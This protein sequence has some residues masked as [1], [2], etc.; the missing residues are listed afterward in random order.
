MERGDR[1]LHL[2]RTGTAVPHRLVEQG[3][4]LGDHRAVP[5][6]AVLILEQ[7]DGAVGVE[8]RRRAGVLQQ[9]QGGEPHDLGL[10]RKQPQQQPREPDRLLAQRRAHMRLAAARRIALVEDEVDHGRHRGEAFGALDRRPA[11]S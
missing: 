11:A 4:P 6:A 7:D 8:P 5:P 1:R 9:Q 10:G 3:Q 2:V